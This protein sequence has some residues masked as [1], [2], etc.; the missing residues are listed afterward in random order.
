MNTTQLTAYDVALRDSA[1]CFIIEW[2]GKLPQA[3]LQEA[4][5]RWASNVYTGPG[6]LFENH[7]TSLPISHHTH[8]H[9]HMTEDSN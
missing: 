7:L 5:D 8:R 3:V 1:I 6:R 4:L 9:T 2:D